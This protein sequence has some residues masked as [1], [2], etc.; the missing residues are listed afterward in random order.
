LK[1]ANKNPKHRPPALGGI[2]QPV[3]AIQASVRHSIYKLVKAVKS[4]QRRSSTSAKICE[5]LTRDEF[6]SFT[7]LQ[8]F[9]ESVFVCVSMA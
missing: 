5:R 7:S 6:T 4:V 1:T 3:C 8:D 9:I 2:N